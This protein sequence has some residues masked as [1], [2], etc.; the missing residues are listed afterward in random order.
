MLSCT[1][2]S[3]LWKTAVIC[4]FDIPINKMNDKQLRNAVQML[5][6]E[7]AMFKRQYEDEIHNLDS[8]NLGKSFT[9]EQN[10]MKAQVRITADAI[11]TMVS[12]T[13]LKEELK[14]YST[15][16]QTAKSITTTVTAEY[17]DT[18]IGNNYVTNA[19]VMSQI[20]QA[21]DNIVISVSEKY[22]TIEDADADYSNLNKRLNN[23]DESISDVKAS[24]SVNKDEIS[25]IVSGNYTEDMLKSYLTGIIISPNSIKMVDN[26]AYSV[27]S[28]EGLRFYDSSNQVE[29]WAIEPSSLYGG[30]LNYYIND[31]NCYRFGTGE[32]GTGYSNVDMVIKA[33]NSQRGRFVVDVSNSANKEVKFVGLSQMA[34]DSPYIYANEKLLATQQWVLDN[35]DNSGSGTNVAVFG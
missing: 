6:D 32:I 25:A 11:K 4:M 22:K 35:T 7:F 1:N 9:I 3:C 21:S 19:T 5:Y 23:T 29:G 28:K 15:I 26:K 10:N 33:I 20:Q 2:W 31:V 27:Y 8:D 30:V 17:I 16:E 12:D 18:L 24:L 14:Q 13:D 34:D